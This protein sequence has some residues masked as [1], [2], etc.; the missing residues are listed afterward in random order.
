M[1]RPEF[2]RS[3]PAF[4]EMFPDEGR[5]ADWIVQARWPDG[6]QCPVCN[7]AAFYARKNKRQM[8]CAGCGEITSVTSGTVLHGTRTPLRT[9]LLAAWLM[10][11]DKRGLSSYQLERQL[12]LSHEVAFVMLHKLRAAMVDPGHGALNGVVEVDESQL[13]A[14]KRGRPA[15]EVFEKVHIVGA[16]EVREFTSKKGEAS[17]RPG[18][19]RFRL[20]PARQKRHLVKFVEENVEPGSVVVTDALTHYNDVALKG[21]ERRIESE[22]LGMKA[23]DILKHYHLAVSNLKTWLAG[24][25]HGRVEPKHLQA[26]LNEYVFR[27]NRRNNLYAAFARLL[28][29]G[30]H[31]LGPRYHQL[32]VDDGE[33][34]GWAHPS[35]GKA[36]DA[37]PA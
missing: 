12:G 1:A 27:F 4:M 35:S 26:Y 30:T 19:I 32:Y 15:A 21:Y 7:H 17:T 11:T 3:L 34:G 13:G 8:E 14:G 23:D 2:P 33:P 9:W 10:V 31:V 5:A 16:V 24:T 36:R 18:R 22:T 6:W 20:V 25:H 29:I 28:G 37:R